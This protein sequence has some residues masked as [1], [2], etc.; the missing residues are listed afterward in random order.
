[1][2]VRRAPLTVSCKLLGATHYLELAVG[3][4]GLFILA[5]P[6]GI[7]FVCLNS[8]FFFADP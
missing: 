6:D 7:K 4:R 1:M 8:N 2:P 3:L 5:D